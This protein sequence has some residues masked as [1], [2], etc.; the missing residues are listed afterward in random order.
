MRALHLW[1]TAWV[2]C[3]QRGTELNCNPSLVGIPVHFFRNVI[4]SNGLVVFLSSYNG[5]NLSHTGRFVSNR[6]MANGVLNPLS[7]SSATTEFAGI[8]KL[9]PDS[10]DVTLAPNPCNCG[11]KGFLLRGGCPN[12]FLISCLWVNATL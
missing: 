1:A 6:N 8:P 3:S 4:I 11:W 10:G 12:L 9:S 5:P 7:I 2:V